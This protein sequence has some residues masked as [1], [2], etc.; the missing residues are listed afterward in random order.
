[1]MNVQ[2]I[3]PL[4]HEE[5]LEVALNARIANGVAPKRIAR[6]EVVRHDS[7]ADAVVE[8]LDCIAVATRRIGAAHVD[9]NVA[10]AA[11]LPRQPIR[12][13][14]RSRLLKGRP[15]VNE[16]DDAPLVP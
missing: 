3:R 1:M 10:R 8:Q 16:M 4:L 6:R 5:S 7:N 12:V 9:G 13:Q 2:Q 14:L 15:A 11:L